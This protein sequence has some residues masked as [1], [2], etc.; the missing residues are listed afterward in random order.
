[1][2][3]DYLF[4]RAAVAFL[5]LPGIFAFFVPILIGYADPWGNQIFVP[6]ILI[7][8][9]GTII[10]MWCIR[11]FYYSGIGTLAPWSP[12][13]NLVVVGLY[14]F[15][16]NPMYLGILLIVLGW[17]IFFRSPLLVIY[18]VSLLL[19]FHLRVVKKEEPWLH[20]RFGLSWEDYQKHVPRWFP[21]RTAWKPS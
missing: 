21:R 8:G 18:N 4:V 19:L 17:A 11:D 5:M 15:V 3:S 1:M 16:R 14:R 6:A 10:V 2:L 12:P 13:T 7:L 9:V 20:K